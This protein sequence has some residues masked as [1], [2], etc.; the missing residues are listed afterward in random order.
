MP[1][2]V[3]PKAAEHRRDEPAP[4]GQPNHASGNHDRMIDRRTRPAEDRQVSDKDRPVEFSDLAVDD[5]G[6][7]KAWDIQE[8]EQQ[9][10]E[11]LMESLREVLT[12]RPDGGSRFLGFVL[13]LV[14]GIA[15]AKRSITNAA[16]AM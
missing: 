12:E 7:G 3:C 15:D 16:L 14:L 2:S 5:A 10:G 11:D 9:E 13:G 4:D 8:D 6:R 1:A